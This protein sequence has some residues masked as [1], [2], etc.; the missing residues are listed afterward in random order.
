M[1]CAGG[2][3]NWLYDYDYKQSQS[4]PVLFPKNS[5]CG[6]GDSVCHGAELPMLFLPQYGRNGR[7][8]FS[9]SDT[10]L[11]VASVIQNYW[12]NMANNNGD[13]GTV[14][15]IKW[16]KFTVL[17]Q[18]SLVFN[19]NGSHTIDQDYLERFLCLFWDSL[20]YCWLESGG[21]NAPSTTG[22][23]PTPDTSQSTE[24]DSDDAFAKGY[25][26]GF[27]YLLCLIILSILHAM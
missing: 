17:G 11:H 19:R 3:D 4:W 9:Y 14:D 2:A 22:D 15:G 18:K 27:G 23:D 16:D 6:T 21:C 24:S 5:D 20:D 10:D 12:T 8:N 1:F 26:Y 13:P 25:N 7:R